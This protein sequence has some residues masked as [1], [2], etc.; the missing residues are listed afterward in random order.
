MR[1]VPDSTPAD[2]TVTDEIRTG[3]DAEYAIRVAGVSKYF[4]IYDKPRDRLK[5]MVMPRL[6][7][8]LGRAP[9]RYHREFHA[10][11]AVSFDIRRGET[12]GIIG[13]NGAGKSTLLQII[14]GT[15]S[16]SAGSVE[17]RG[18]IAALLEL[19]A[20]FNPEF[21]GRENVFMNGAILGLSREEVA[22]RFDEIAAFADIGEFIEQPVKSYSSGMYVRLA[23][24]V[25]ACVDPDILIVDE[26]LSVGDIGFQYKCFQR[27]EALKKQGVTILMV[28]HSTGSIL[29]YA[30]RCI[31]LDAGS[32]LHDTPDV[33]AAVLAYEKG[34]LNQAQ[35]QVPRLEGASAESADACLMTVDQ[36]K[37]IQQ[38]EVNRELGEKRFGTARAIV[39]RV[40]LFKAD[41]ASIA[42]NPLLKPNEE[43]VFRFSLLAAEAIRNVALGVSI[44]GVRGGDIWGDNNFNANQPLNLAPGRNVVEYRVRLPI[45]SGEY[46]VH[47][48]L[49]CFAGDSREELDQRRP[50]SHLR[51][52]S[53]RDQVGVVHAPIRISLPGEAEQ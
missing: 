38:N 35:A 52:W 1:E 7:R 9:R 21:T 33:L 12:V 49:A 45:S 4:P 19:G 34:M 37:A 42:D 5:Q 24:A 32:I 22:R 46:L 26:A 15:L 3:P 48:G 47:C 6:F 41:G 17:T 13:R 20:G 14:G 39:E 29:E 30:D 40:D 8:L 11:N 28:T 44:S 31:V 27:M 53:T 36:L 51:F 50:V 2:R 23:F 18:R 10:L 43:I 16:P 25:Q